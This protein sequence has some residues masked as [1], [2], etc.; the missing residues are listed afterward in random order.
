MAETCPGHTNDI[1][2]LPDV[3]TNVVSDDLIILPSFSLI[4]S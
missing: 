4:F 3:R 1:I 2:L